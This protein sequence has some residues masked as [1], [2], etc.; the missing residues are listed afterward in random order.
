MKRQAKQAKREARADDTPSLSPTSEADLLA[1]FARLS[2]K[3]EAKA[4]SHADYTEERRRI[5]NELGIEPVR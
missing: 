4:L 3:Y 2:A 5:L 1:E